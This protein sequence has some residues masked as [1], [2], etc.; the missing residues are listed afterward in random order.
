[1]SHRSLRYAS[2]AALDHVAEDMPAMPAKLPADIVKCVHALKL[3]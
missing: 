2:F 3:N 1:M